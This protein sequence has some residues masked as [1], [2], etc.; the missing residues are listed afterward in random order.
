MQDSI[1]TKIIKGEM[2]SHKVYEDA[3]TF[4]FMSIHPIQPGQVVVVPKK[5]VDPVWD[6][7]DEDYQALMATGKKVARKMKAAFPDKSHIALHIEG[8]EVA[9]AHLKIF[10]FSTH[11]EFQHVPDTTLEPDHTVLAEMAARLRMEDEL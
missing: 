10:P 3:K 1:F 5:Q 6:L 8:L 2:P 4:V 9:H 7:S 11:E